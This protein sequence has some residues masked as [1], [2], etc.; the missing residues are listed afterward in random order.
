[1]LTQEEYSK[2]A[3][4]KLVEANPEAF[5]FA[6]LK[7]SSYGERKDMAP[8]LVCLRPEL[9]QKSG[10]KSLAEAEPKQAPQ[11]DWEKQSFVR[12]RVSAAVVTKCIK[13]IREIKKQHLVLWASAMNIGTDMLDMLGLKKTDLSEKRLQKKSEKELLRLIFL[14]NPHVWASIESAREI[15][16]DLKATLKEATKAAEA[17][18]DAKKAEEAKGE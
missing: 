2:P 14:M 12:E 1:M 8:A 16:I 13:E 5:Q 4:K 9:L 7:P 3:V 17:E 11:R 10:N 6:V 18:Y 15:D